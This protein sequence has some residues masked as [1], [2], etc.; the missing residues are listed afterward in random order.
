M[1]VDDQY[2][3][4]LPRGTAVQLGVVHQ[5]IVGYQNYQQVIY[6]KSKRFGRPVV[7]A[8]EEFNGLAAQVVRMPKNDHEGARIEQNALNLIQAGAP[9]TLLDNC[10]DFVSR[11]YDGKS[12]SETRNLLVGAGIVVGVLCLIR[13]R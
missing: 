8:P 1:Y 6:N 3:Q 2:F 4:P 5:G 7:S 12:G 9:W 10:Q 11:C 13:P